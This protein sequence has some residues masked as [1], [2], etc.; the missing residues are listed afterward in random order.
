MKIHYMQHVSFEGLGSIE[1][2]L[3]E[4]SHS[5]S[6][7]RMFANEPFPEISDMD[8][9]IVM[10]GS[11]GVHDDKAYPWLK[12]EKQFIKN[13]IQ[14]GKVVLGICLGAQLIAEVMDA[15]VYKNKYREIGW[16]DINFNPN[17][18]HTL[19]KDIFPKQI[20]VFH[21]HGDTFDI[22]EDAIPIASS[23]A[24]PNQGFIF[25]NR[26]IALQFHLETTPESAKALIDNCSNELD[27]SKYVQNEREILSNYLRFT[28]INQLMDQIVYSLQ[29]STDE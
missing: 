6:V 7:T 23:E 4:S 9:L 17:L 10:G 8:W 26:V 29:K 11:M 16:F 20:E 13:V 1:V 24:T 3:K 27:G 22:P 14:S 19:L 2:V 25:D 28:K 5:I 21:W 12:T 15:Q 18:N